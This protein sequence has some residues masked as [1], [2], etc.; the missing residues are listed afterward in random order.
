MN[1]FLYDTILTLRDGEWLKFVGQLG[2][3]LSD[4]L[5]CLS[6]GLFASVARLASKSIQIIT[7]EVKSPWQRQSMMKWKQSYCSI[8]ILIDEINECF[9]GFLLIFFIKHN[10][11][12]FVFIYSIIFS[13]MTKEYTYVLF[14]YKV[15]S[16]VKAVYQILIVTYEAVRMSKKVSLN[17]YPTVNTQIIDFLV[18][19]CNLVKELINQRYLYNALQSD[20]IIHSVNVAMIYFTVRFFY[21]RRMT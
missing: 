14:V 15:G 10:I 4:V 3:Y 19:A 17:C 13:V 12:L 7:E 6:I 1:L 11:D 18:Q 2:I 8:S 21:N 5:E 20:V 16:L 9:A